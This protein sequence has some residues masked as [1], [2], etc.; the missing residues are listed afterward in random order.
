VTHRLELRLWP[1][2]F[3]VCRL[4]EGDPVPAWAMAGTL[5]SLTRTPR[6][7]SLVCEAELVPA[8]IRAETGWRLLEVQGPLDFSLT[9]ILAALTTPLAQAAI[10][11]FAFSTFDTDYLMVR[12]E[13]LEPTLQ[14]LRQAGH[15]IAGPRPEAL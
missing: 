7:L 2:F 6:E 8:G 4:P 3:A 5:W 12:G 1:Q 9:G 15:V 11:I 13:T 14:A 10:S